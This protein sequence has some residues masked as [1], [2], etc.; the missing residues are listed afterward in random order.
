MDRRRQGGSKQK[1]MKT[2]SEKTGLKKTGIKKI[3][4]DEVDEGRDLR[5]QG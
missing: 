5:K 3:V 4:T 2:E 1:L